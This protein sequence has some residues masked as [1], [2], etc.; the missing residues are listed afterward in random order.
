MIYNSLRGDI[1][2]PLSI[3]ST[4]DEALKAFEFN[5]EIDSEQYGRSNDWNISQIGRDAVIDI[6]GER[7]SSDSGNTIYDSLRGLHITAWL[8]S[9]PY[10]LTVGAATPFSVETANDAQ[11]TLAVVDKFIAAIDS[12]RAELGAVQNRL[13]S[14]IRNQSGVSENVSAAR[15]RIQDADFASET[16]AMIQ[17]NILQQASQSILIQANQRP[18]IALS[19]LQS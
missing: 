5:V 3:T 2:R 11:N 4:G 12:K 10:R 17:Q 9:G 15:S 18:E 8:A 14:V 13:E 6:D 16:A 7:F 19:L 1:N